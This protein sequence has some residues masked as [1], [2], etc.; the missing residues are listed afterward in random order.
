MEEMYA[1]PFR[2]D[3]LG[4]RGLF[5]AVPVDGVGR[6]VD[7]DRFGTNAHGCALNTRTT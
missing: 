2:S 1:Y 7:Q 5:R 3:R 4:Q 6:P